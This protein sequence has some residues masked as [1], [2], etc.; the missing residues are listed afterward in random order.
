MKD[1]GGKINDPL[2]GNIMVFDP[3]TSQDG[4]NDSKITTQDNNEGHDDTLLHPEKE[5]TFRED[6][7][8]LFEQLDDEFDG[9][10]RF[11]ELKKLAELNDEYDESS[12]PLPPKMIRFSDVSEEVDLMKDSST[13][14]VSP[15]TKEHNFIMPIDEEDGRKY[16]M[17]LAGSISPD[18]KKENQD[19]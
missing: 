11:E 18:K 14:N 6:A 8:D 15:M 16:S 2:G 5:A 1:Q 10:L 17:N 9:Y 4:T 12:A 7:W 19:P 3:F 13:V